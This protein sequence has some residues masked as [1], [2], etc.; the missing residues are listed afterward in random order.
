[1]KNSKINSNR[2]FGL[3]FFLI[4]FIISTYPIIYGND[5]KVWF[6]II[7]LIFLFVGLIKPRLLSPFNII[8]F[9]LGIYLGKFFSPIIIAVIYLFLITPI[10][11]LM[12]ILGHNFLDLK[13]NDKNSYWIKRNKTNLSNMK[14]QF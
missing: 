7:S 1:M 14:N 4:F 3:F 13:V 6:F 8:W 9:K 5:L 12:R 10:G 2:I 11:L